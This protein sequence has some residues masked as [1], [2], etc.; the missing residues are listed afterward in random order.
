VAQCQTLPPFARPIVK[1]RDIG[2][3][4]ERVVLL[5]GTDWCH[6]EI[7]D[8]RLRPLVMVLAD[9][10]RRGAYSAFSWTAGVPVF[11]INWDA[12]KA[13][14]VQL[15]IEV[16]AVTAPVISAERDFDFDV[17]STWVN[18][19]WT[20]YEARTRRPDGDLWPPGWSD[21]LHH[22]YAQRV[23]AWWQRERR[24]AAA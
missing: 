22:R 9:E 12:P 8:E 1:A 14:H 10:Y 5:L 7:W 18:G 13:L 15:L 19:D 4:P 11:V 16:A 3:H 21:E 24:R 17:D 23:D 20:I 6:R 2:Q